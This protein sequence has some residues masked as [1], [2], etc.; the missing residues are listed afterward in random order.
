MQHYHVLIKEPNGQRRLGAYARNKTA[1]RSE[2]R[3]EMEMTPVGVGEGRRVAI[4]KA[5][6]ARGLRCLEGRG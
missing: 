5:C 3:I 6:N 4:V 1:A 2:A